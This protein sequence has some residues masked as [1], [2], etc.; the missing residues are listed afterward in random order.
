MLQGGAAL[1]I[2][3]DQEII[4]CNGFK[5]RFIPLGKAFEQINAPLKSLFFALGAGGCVAEQPQDQ[6]LLDPAGFAGG[7][8]EA[9]KAVSDGFIQGHS[10]V[11]REGR[12]FRMQAFS[13]FP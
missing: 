8:V 9:A 10:F 3:G 1:F 4:Q 7:Q 11:R 13:G 12:H 2:I 5:G 6:G